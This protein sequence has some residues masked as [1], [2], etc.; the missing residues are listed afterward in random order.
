M[1]QAVEKRWPTKEFLAEKK[2][3]PIIGNYSGRKQAVFKFQI[4]FM[5]LEIELYVD[6]K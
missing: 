6:V 1:L 3:Q 4:L 5:Q 2:N